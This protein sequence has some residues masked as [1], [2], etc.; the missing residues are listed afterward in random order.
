MNTL[1]RF[2]SKVDKSDDCWNWTAGKAHNGYGLFKVRSK[3]IRA[4][5]FSWELANG[6]IPKGLQINHKC[7]NPACVN[8]DHL[9]A[10]TQK[11][12]RQDAV[13]RGRTATGKSNGMYT[14]PENR[15]TGEFNGNSKLTNMEMDNIRRL[16]KAGNVSM[17]NLG[18]EYGVSK[19]AIWHI[20][21]FERNK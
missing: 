17:Q 18:D 10:G 20:V 5:R 12:N 19:Q 14:H 7:D 4:H 11:Q 2:W 1:E 3:T 21:H 15:R 8:P 6:K 13:K 9:Y 16:Y